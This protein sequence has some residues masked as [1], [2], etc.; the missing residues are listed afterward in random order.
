[1]FHFQ[2][3]LMIPE[4]QDRNSLSIKPGFARGIACGGMLAPIEL[5][6]QLQPWAIEVDDVRRHRVLSTPLQALHA[7]CA[8]VI[9]EIAF[10]I[11]GLRTKLA[12]EALRSAW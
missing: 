8:Q 11:G 3:H 9:P 12:G 5:D 4:P 2:Q 7:S 10:C 1:V 6:R